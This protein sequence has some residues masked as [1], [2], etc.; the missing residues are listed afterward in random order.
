MTTVDSTSSALSACSRGR[1]HRSE[2][3][4]DHESSNYDSAIE[5]E[6]AN[7]FKKISFA[8]KGNRH[9]LTDLRQPCFVSQ[10]AQAAHFNSCE[11]SAK[12]RFP[13]AWPRI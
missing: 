1:T 11:L 9:F 2:T 8:G 12:R 13:A 3:V 4:S 10:C 5:P 6:Y 7:N